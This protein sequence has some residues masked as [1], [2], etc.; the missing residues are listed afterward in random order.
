M[1]ARPSCLLPRRGFTLIEAMTAVVLTSIACSA[2]LYSVSQAIQASNASLGTSRANLLAQDLM[3]E[4]SARRWADP[5]YPSHWGPESGETR[6]KTR[7]AFNDL[8]DY[9]GWNGPPQT[10]YGVTYDTLQQQLFPNVKS[11]EFSPYTC[12][13]HVKYV[14]STG[15]D[16]PTGKTST[17]RQ[18]TVEVTH[19]DYAPEKLSRIFYDPAPLLGRT[20][21]YDP[22]A[23][24]RVAEV[25]IVP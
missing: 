16:L 8:D 4:I 10:R 21:W 25:R 23:T 9:D 6:T 18:V 12:T 20:T 14:T 22:N 7:A 1:R 19:P 3:N 2:M 5:S 24:E 11:H 17:Y 13:V 15:Q